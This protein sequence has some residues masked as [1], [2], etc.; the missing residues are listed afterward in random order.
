M[1]RLWWLRFMLI[2]LLLATCAAHD[3]TDN[4]DNDFDEKN[5]FD[6]EEKSVKPVSLYI[7][8]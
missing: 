2:G 1:R 3:E 6:D 4:N 7:I 5:V 8:S